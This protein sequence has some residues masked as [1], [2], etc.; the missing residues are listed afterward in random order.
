MFFKYLA[1]LEHA[2]W[3]NIK[4]LIIVILLW[5]MSLLIYVPKLLGCKLLIMYGH[6]Q[7]TL[8]FL[9]MAKISSQIQYESVLYHK[10]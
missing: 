6:H 8:A 9:N 10:P 3:I 4:L 2:F 5:L 7:E 1:S